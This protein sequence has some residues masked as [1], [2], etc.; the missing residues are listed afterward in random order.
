[1][2]QFKNPLGERLAKLPDDDARV[3]YLI[4]LVERF[5]ASEFFDLFTWACEQFEAATIRVLHS[6]TG[7]NAT[8]NCLIATGRLQAIPLLTGLLFATD[9]LQGETDTDEEAEDA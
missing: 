5:E 3:K 4:D 7:E 2:A 6:Q 8:A 1:M 9:L